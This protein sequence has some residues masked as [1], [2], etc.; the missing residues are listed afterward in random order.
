MLIAILNSKGGVG[1]STIA[2]HTTLWL[3][4]QGVNV[5]LLDADE[6]GSSSA[7]V[8]AAA[9]GLP[10]LRY[11]TAREIL[12]KVPRARLL[13]EAIVADGPASLNAE[14]ASLA[15]QA[16]LVV[17]PLQPSTLDI[18]ATFRTARAIHKLRFHP[19][20]NGRPQALTVLNRATS[21]TRLAQ[22]AVTT[23]QQYGFPVSPVVLEARVAYM[24]ACQKSTVVW[25][26]GKRAATAAAEIT[27]V[28]ERMLKQLPD[29]PVAARV[30]KQRQA[31][32]QATVLAQRSTTTQN[33]TLDKDSVSPPPSP[34]PSAG[35]NSP[36]VQNAGP[37]H[38]D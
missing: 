34:Q 11:T 36:A 27:R 25:R 28:C 31:M 37:L 4:E 10:V 7:W 26:M 17:M 29:H 6:Q 5:A 32:Q 20:R 8:T 16:D 1:K 12:A 19:G 9:P 30:L 15:T 35:V 14:I 21:R 23:I 24:E 2:V 33:V 22:L 38:T 18:A 13:Y 3:R